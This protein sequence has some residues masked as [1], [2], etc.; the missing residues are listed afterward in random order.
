MRSG[1]KFCWT[2]TEL[3]A[4]ASVLDDQ[5]V[6]KFLTECGCEWEFNPPHTSHFGG[7]WERQINTIRGVLDAMFIEL[8]Q[9]QLTH[10]LLSI[11]IV[12][13]SPIAALPSDTDDPQP[14]SLQ[15][16]SLWRHAQPN[17]LQASSCGQISTPAVHGDESSSLLNN[18]GPGGG[19]NTCRANSRDKSGRRCSE[20]CA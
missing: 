19:E 6:E 13:A 9:S 2:K 17:P 10:E 1:H 18:F 16:Y 7:V 4:A 12:N 8:G 20:T 15:C 14:L 5:K 3:D 11:C